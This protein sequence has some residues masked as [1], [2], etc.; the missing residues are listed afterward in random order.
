MSAKA[1]ETERQPE[2]IHSIAM[3]WCAYRMHLEI[4]VKCDLA[5][6]GPPR[7]N[8][9]MASQQHNILHRAALVVAGS[10]QLRQHPGGHA[11]P[12]RYLY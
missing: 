2:Q 12:E 9:A 10:T 6:G 7:T 11:R 5:L 4:D 1:S 3:Q 8:M